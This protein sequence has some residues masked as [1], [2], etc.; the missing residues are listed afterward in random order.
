MPAPIA[1]FSYPSARVCRYRLSHIS[2]AVTWSVRQLQEP[3]ASC[4]A[5]ETKAIPLPIPP[6][7]CSEECVCGLQEQLQ[8]FA[9][10]EKPPAK[11]RKA[12]VPKKDAVPDFLNGRQLR[13][14]QACLGLVFH[15]IMPTAKGVI[16]HNIKALCKYLAIDSVQECC[17][18][19]CT[20]PP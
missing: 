10:R 5:R 16:L 6:F 19:K 20:V 7:N 4:K 14:Y 12:G 17:F 18:N 11:A 9:K 1:P 8:L 13:D 3:A 15:L 2:L